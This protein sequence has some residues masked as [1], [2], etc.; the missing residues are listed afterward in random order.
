MKREVQLVDRVAR[1]LGSKF[2]IGR[3]PEDRAPLQFGIGDDAAVFRIPAGHQCVVSCD[4]FVE[5]IHFRLDTQP[6]DSVGY[7]CL[8]RATSDLAAMGATPR[9]FLLTLA[10]P[11]ARTGRWLDAFLAGMA[12]ASKQLRI[13]AIGGDTTQSDRISISVTVIGEV[14]S[15]YA[16]SRSG[17]RPGDL[18]YVSGTLGR[19][20]LGLELT[21]AGL[22]RKAAV[23]DAVEP[24]LHPQAR[25]KLGRWL[26]QHKIPS[27]MIDLSDGL[28][29]D[30]AR[31][32]AASGAGAKLDAERIPQ[33]SVGP[34]AARL[35]RTKRFNSLAAAM[36][37]GDDYE[38][39]FTL[40]PRKEKL[41]RNAPG[42]SQ[43][44][45]IGEVTRAKEIVLREADGRIKRLAPLGWDS[46]R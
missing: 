13:R 31:V 29:T 16:V 8:A 26:A 21:L 4:A 27:A 28:S 35:I 46:F 22:A 44:R 18:I 45:R 24:H 3:V 40:P 6:P 42:F 15:G 36:H 1:A 39:L 43:L 23:R 11:G 34:A 25:V 37:G 14:R 9:Y 33:V 41:L 5:G 19:A 17:A 32:C 7:K 10:I 20:Q 2:A 12:R 30:L 38:L